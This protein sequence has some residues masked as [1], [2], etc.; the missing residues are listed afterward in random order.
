LAKYKLDLVGV[1]GIGWDKVDTVKAEGLF[2][3]VK[4]E[5]EVIKGEQEFFVLHRTVSAGKRVE[6]VSDRK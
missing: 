1:Q 4:K 3:L 6:F 2:F 5:T